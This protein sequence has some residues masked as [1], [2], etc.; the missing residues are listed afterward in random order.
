MD[1]TTRATYR[2]IQDVVI[3]EAEPVDNPSRERMLWKKNPNFDTAIREAHAS[4][5]NSNLNTVAQLES[6]IKT[7]TAR[8]R[9]TN[10]L[11]LSEAMKYLASL[12]A[13]IERAQRQNLEIDMT[14][15][16]HRDVLEYKML[17]WW[18]R[19]GFKVR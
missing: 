1:E 7:T 8:L 14:L 12:I 4:M 9:G 5:E 13:L 17:E 11:S 3:H 15:L 6:A 16:R 19:T 18:H 10:K 2:N